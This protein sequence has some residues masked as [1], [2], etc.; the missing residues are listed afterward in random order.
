[1]RTLLFILCLLMATP[2]FAI[3]NPDEKLADPALETRAETLT[4]T[5]RCVVCQNQ[6]VE[7]SNADIARDLRI[8][9]RKQMVQGQSDDQ[10]KQYLRARYGDY[11]LLK[12]PVTDRTYLLWFAPVIIL[13]GGFILMARSF[14][15]R[16]RS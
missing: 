9:V 12:P 2:A 6:S 13:A 14:T 7:D 1:M 5:L 16:R 11:I 3:M 15:R 8:T 4:R 10:I